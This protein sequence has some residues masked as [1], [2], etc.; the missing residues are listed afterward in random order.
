MF[1][2]PLAIVIHGGKDTVAPGAFQDPLAGSERLTLASAHDDSSVDPILME[3]GQGGLQFFLDGL[4]A[5]ACAT[6]R[7]MPSGT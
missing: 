3:R 6:Y 7:R 2:K 1:R 4:P 5:D